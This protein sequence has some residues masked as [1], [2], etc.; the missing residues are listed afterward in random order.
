M[1]EMEQVILEMRVAV[2][3]A[4]QEQQHQVEMVHMEQHLQ[5]LE[6]Q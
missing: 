2:A 6:L 5:L 4:V 3:V 1:V